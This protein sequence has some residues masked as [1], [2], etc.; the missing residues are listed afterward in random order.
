MN[1]PV[2][3]GV[4][5]FTEWKNTITYKCNEGCTKLIY[6]D[7]ELK[8]YLLTQKIADKKNPNLKYNLLGM[9]AVSAP[10]TELYKLDASNPKSTTQQVLK[11]NYFVNVTTQ[12]EINGLINRLLKLTAFS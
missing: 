11:L 6:E 10:F 8:S 2:C 9:K 4:F 7:N 3:Q 1:C 12:T 5:S